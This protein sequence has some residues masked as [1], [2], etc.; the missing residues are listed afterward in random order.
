MTSYRSY[1]IGETIVGWSVTQKCPPSQIFEKFE[2]FNTL[3]SFRLAGIHL[4]LKSVQFYKGDM[5]SFNWSLRVMHAI[6]NIIC[7]FI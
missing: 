7:L 5:T 3:S 4:M 2:H 6:A 1:E